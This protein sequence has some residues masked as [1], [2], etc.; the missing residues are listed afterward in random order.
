MDTGHSDQIE[1]CVVFPFAKR[2]K[3]IQIPINKKKAQGSSDM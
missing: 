2:E 1:K 3:K